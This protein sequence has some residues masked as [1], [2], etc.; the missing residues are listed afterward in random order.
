MGGLE[1]SP[2]AKPGSPL[3]VVSKVLLEQGYTHYLFIL[4]LA[5]SCNVSRIEWLQQTA[6]IVIWG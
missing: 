2:W 1:K 5:V 6:Y 3:F 4:S